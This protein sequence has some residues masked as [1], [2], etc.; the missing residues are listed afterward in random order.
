ME[1]AAKYIK[2][3]LRFNYERG[4][5]PGFVVAIA[6]DGKIIF[7]QAYGFA[8]LEDKTPMTPPHLFRIASHSKTF[9][10]T[11][12]MQLQERGKLRIDDSIVD[13]LPWL[14][15]HKDRRWRSVTI[16]QLLSHG[17]GVI[18]DGLKNDYWS[19]EELFPSEAEFKKDLLAANLVI[20]NNTKLKYSNFGYTLL[21]MLVSEVSGQ[22]YNRYVI[23]NIVKLLELKNTGPELNEHIALKLVTGYSMMGPHK[24]RLPIAPIDTHAM[25]PATGFYS[26]AADLCTYFMAQM[27]G[28][29]KLLSDESK[30]EMQKAAWRA[31]NTSDWEEYG[32]GF[33]IEHINDHLLLGHGGGF[34]G[35]ITKSYFDSEKKLVV[36]VLTNANGSLPTYMDKG[37]IKVLDFFQK[38]RPAPGLEKYEGRYMNL[39]WNAD[40]VA[41][42]NK[43]IVGTADG[44][45]PF[46]RPEEI[47]HIKDDTFRISKADSFS[48]T[49]EEVRFQVT[50]NGKVSAMFYAGGTMLPEADYIKKMASTRQIGAGNT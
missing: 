46:E 47:K 37:I 24:K 4:D 11:A 31:E 40:V 17:A 2:D 6:H 38:N 20:N 32:L 5:T 30:K 26:N 33:E 49:E 25:S 12:I 39:W 22:P 19:V 15:Q 45:E 18:R 7:N 35:N 29:G 34:P 21:G 13:Y 1:R 14:K 10:A 28:S 36:I 48:S 44:W 41:G 50:K 16:R 43:L 8:D 42:K 23:E 3:W 27:V 9:T